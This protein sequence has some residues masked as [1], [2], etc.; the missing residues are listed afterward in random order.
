LAPNRGPDWVYEAMVAT[1]TIW[2]ICSVAVFVSMAFGRNTI[3]HR[4]LRLGDL[5]WKAVAV[6]SM[7][8]AGG[9]AFLFDQATHLPVDVPTEIDD[10]AGVPG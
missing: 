8:I 5:D 9:V 6:I 7:L 3:L 2:V 4:R 1:F 10:R